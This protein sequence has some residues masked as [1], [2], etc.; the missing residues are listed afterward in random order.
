[1]R[2]ARLL[3]STFA[4]AAAL[5]G[6]VEPPDESATSGISFEEYRATALR[7]PSTGAYVVDWDIVLPD[8]QA[9]HAYWTRYQQGALMVYTV[10]GADVKWDATQRKQLRYCIGDGFG[11]NRQKVVAAMQAATVNGWEKLGDVK[12]IHDKRAHWGKEVW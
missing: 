12:F 11:A 3:A 4:A 6:C 8:E 10:D 5:G 9:L 7:D 2:P 1:M